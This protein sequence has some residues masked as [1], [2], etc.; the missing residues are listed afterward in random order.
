M[1][2][3]NKKSFDHLFGIDIDIYNDESRLLFAHNKY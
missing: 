1:I 2:D 3:D